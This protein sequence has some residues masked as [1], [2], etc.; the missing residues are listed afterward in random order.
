MHQ[1]PR[2]I[3]TTALCSCQRFTLVLYRTPRGEPF[4]CQLQMRFFVTTSPIGLMSLSLRSHLTHGGVAAAAAAA[5]AAT[6]DAAVAA[7]TAAAA[8]SAVV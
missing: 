6:A 7:M 2:H 5:A 8:S 4:N 3:R 1:R